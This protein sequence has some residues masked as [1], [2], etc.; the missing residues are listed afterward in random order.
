MQVQA[1]PVTDPAIIGAS[2]DNQV[3]IAVAVKARQVQKQQGEA[4]IELIQNAAAVSTQLDSGHI[5]IQL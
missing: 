4:V 1:N 3:Q 2:I 5:D